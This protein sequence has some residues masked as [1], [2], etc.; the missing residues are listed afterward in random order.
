VNLGMT[1]FASADMGFKFKL[2]SGHYFSAGIFYDHGLVDMARNHVWTG[3]SELIEIDSYYPA[4][5][6]VHS[7]LKTKRAIVTKLTPFTAGVRFGITFMN[8]RRMGEVLPPIKVESLDTMTM[9][10]EPQM[11]LPIPFE[12]SI[13]H[14]E[15]ERGTVMTAR[16]RET[17]D[18]VYLT[19][20]EYP[21]ALLEIIGHSC[22]TGPDEF[23]LE[24]S[25]QRAEI[26]ANYLIDK[27]ISAERF[28]L[29]GVGADRPMGDNETREGRAENRRVEIFYT[30]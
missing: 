3:A 15:D 29:N 17:L 11:P 9:V 18:E 4:R 19:M 13:I 21:E 14:F 20:L 2:H 5:F 1:A 25:Q 23:R 12:Q 6:S 30:R 28:I 24:L 10:F 8:K 26:V 16:A 27:G 7:V 22:T